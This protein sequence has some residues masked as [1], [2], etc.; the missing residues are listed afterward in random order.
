MR[1][2]LK[3]KVRLG[4]TEVDTSPVPGVGDRV[5]R[6]RRLRPRILIAAFVVDEETVGLGILVGL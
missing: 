5:H 3:E 4:L 1:E 2:P 6:P